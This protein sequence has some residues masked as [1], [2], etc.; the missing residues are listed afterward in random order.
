MSAAT[1]LALC[2]A[3]VLLPGLTACHWGSRP[4]KFPPA[5][6]P[7]GAR[8]SLRVRGESADRI[9]ELYAVDS[10]GVTV[11]D[12]RLTRIHWPALTTLDVF[13]LSRRYGVHSGGSTVTGPQ[14]ERLAAVS[15]F[16]QGLT[17]ELLTR[18]LAR[19]Q[20]DALVEVR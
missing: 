3:I 4:E 19:L 2:A 14:R 18:V 15:R 1:R 20:Q 16:P 6:S 8:V 5:L 9:G 17:G 13:G 10:V 12:A 11:H 7:V